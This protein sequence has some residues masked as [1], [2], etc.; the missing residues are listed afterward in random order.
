MEVLFGIAILFIVIAFRFISTKIKEVLEAIKD[1]RSDIKFL[2]DHS[3]YWSDKLGKN[4]NEVYKSIFLELIPTIENITD[5][6]ILPAIYSLNRILYPIQRMSEHDF[7]QIEKS[8]ELLKDKIKTLN[9]ELN[10]E[11]LKYEILKKEHEVLKE[12]MKNY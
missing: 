12:N 2:K 6:K 7:S 9:A 11:R 8:N 1:I 5:S 3:T 4:V 10:S